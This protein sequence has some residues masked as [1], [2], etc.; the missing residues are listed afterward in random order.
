MLTGNE[1]SYGRYVATLIVAKQFDEYELKALQAFIHKTANIPD[2]VPALQ[3]VIRQI[4]KLTGFP[5]RKG[6]G[7][8]G[9]ITLWKGMWRMVG[10]ALSV[11]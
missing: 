11:Y 7:E 6:D 2:E 3:T 1:I 5:G 4:A 8:P 9:M 10:I